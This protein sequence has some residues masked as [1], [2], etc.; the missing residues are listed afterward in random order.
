MGRT[1]NPALGSLLRDPRRVGNAVAQRV[2]MLG[3]RLKGLHNL[4][5]RLKSRQSVFSTV[6]SE[7]RWGSDESGSGFG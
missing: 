7:R 2:L 4:R 5:W 3:A 1:S 6:Y